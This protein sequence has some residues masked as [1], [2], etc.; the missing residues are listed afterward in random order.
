MKEKYKT[1]LT[2]VKVT[3]ECINVH[4]VPRLE[5][6]RWWE[7]QSSRNYFYR[8]SFAEIPFTLVG[9]AFVCVFVSLFK[10]KLKIKII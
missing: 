4:H 9:F 6:T 7:G 8:Y 10:T 2:N 3:A 5:D 1:L